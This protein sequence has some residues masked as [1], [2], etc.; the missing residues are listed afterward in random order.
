MK[1]K[2]IAMILMMT[3]MLCFMIPMKSEA[4]TVTTDTKDKYCAS[5]LRYLTSI[6]YCEARGEGYAGQKA[7]GIVVMN[8]VESELFPN[9]IEEVIY[10]SGQFAP[11]SNGSLSAALGMYDSQR[12]T[13]EWDKTMLSCFQAAEEVLEGSRKIEIND[14]EQDMSDYLFFS[15][16]INGARYRLGNHMFR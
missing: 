11:V 10:Q 15:V 2:K 16:Y 1:T 14:G 9:D 4:A 6:I 7:V 12:R 8:R 3:A 13:G 5:D